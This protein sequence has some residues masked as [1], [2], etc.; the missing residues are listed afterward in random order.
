M[1]KLSEFTTDPHNANKGTQRGLKA[2]DTSVRKYG[3]GRSILADRKG[4]I[5]AGNKTAERAADIGIED[6]IVVESDG[7]K[8]VVV[9]RTD[10][11]LEDDGGKAR[12]LATYDNRSGQLDLDWD[13]DALST[14]DADVLKD[15]WTVDE[16]D[17]LGIIEKPQ[18]DAEP[19][20]DRAA[21]LQEKWQVKTGD[22]WR[23]GDHRLLCGDSTKRED[24]E[25]VMGGEKAQA[26]ICDPPFSVRDD[27]WDKF[28]GNEF[29]IF[30]SKW[31]AIADSISDVIVSF[32]ADHNVPLLLAAAAQVSIP[33][34]RSL[35]WR[36][37]PGSQFAGATLDGFWFDFE[38]IEVFKKPQFKPSK[39]IKM[40]VLEY[41]TVTNQE[42]GCEKPLGLLSDLVSAYSEDSNIVVDFFNGT[43]TVIVACQN[44]GRKCRAIEISP[45]Y[46]AVTL[47]RMAQA[48]PG[49]EIE[50]I[51]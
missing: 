5:I 18:G 10:L 14:V 44:L 30:T 50:R 34:R 48:F 22:L 9:K 17:E 2:L 29:M 12:A 24:V 27:N 1:A 42:H 33:F 25:R 37:P 45:E 31:L 26:L 4:R 16:L 8:L 35:V 13:I 36:K 6:V 47:E 39:N 40:A 38:M 11:D 49:I 32:M 23:I 28:D 3:M 15:L 19:Q 20:I 7:T 43:G 46:C 41:R 21:E 51:L